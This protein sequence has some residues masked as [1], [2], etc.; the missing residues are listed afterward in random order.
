MRKNSLLT[1]MHPHADGA[2]LSPSPPPGPLEAPASQGGDQRLLQ[3]PRSGPPMQPTPIGFQG[4][5]VGQHGVPAPTQ[6]L[7]PP[8]QS[9]STQHAHMPP[10]PRHL[11]STPPLPNQASHPWAPPASHPLSSPPLTPQK[12]PHVQVSCVCF[13]RVFISNVGGGMCVF[14]VKGVHDI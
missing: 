7:A 8:A 10:Q 3:V 1:V 6:C 11:Q 12:V 14:G 13:K 9:T 4:P 2:S 5:A